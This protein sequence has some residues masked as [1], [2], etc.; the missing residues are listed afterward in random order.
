VRVVFDASVLVAAFA[1]RGLCADLFEACVVEHD[2]ATSAPILEET[3]RVLVR[4]IRLPAP[5]ATAIRHFLEERLRQ[6]TP[7]VVDGT[8]CRDRDDIAVLGT[9]CAAKADCIVSGD[10]DLLVHGSFAGIPILKPREL[11]A[12]LSST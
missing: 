11:C 2:F 9:A 4:K 5:R 12:Q 10:Q 3:E 6:V 1:A 8:P 7:S